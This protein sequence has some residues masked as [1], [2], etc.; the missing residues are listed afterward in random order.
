[1]TDDEF[2]DLQ[3]KALSAAELMES[4]AWLSAVAAV[5][6]EVVADWSSAPWTAPS[7]REQKYAEIKG[8][9]L[10]QDRLRKWIN[11]SRYEAA[12]RDK[13]RLRAV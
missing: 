7:V 2:R 11:D 13:R 9:Q 3:K 10:V 12:E 6:A 1:M 8:L 4:P 5:Q